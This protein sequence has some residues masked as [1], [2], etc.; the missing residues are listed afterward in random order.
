[1]PQQQPWTGEQHI[2]HPNNHSE[3]PSN[4]QNALAITHHPEHPSNQPK[5]L[6]NILATTLNTRAEQFWKII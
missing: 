1:M 2:K 6:I 3:R 4:M 5:T